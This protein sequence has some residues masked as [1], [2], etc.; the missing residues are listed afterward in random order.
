NDSDMIDDIVIDSKWCEDLWDRA[1]VYEGHLLKTGAPRCDVLY[2]DRTDYQKAFREK[3]HL[4]E[5]AKAVMYAPTFREGAKNGKRFVFSEIWSVDFKR[6]LTNLEKKFS[7]TWYLCVRV[8]PQLAP[9][10]DD[11][12]NPDVQDRIINVSKADDMYE[13][14]AGMDAYITDYSSACFEAGLTGM[15]VFLYA[16]DTKK[17]EKDRGQLLWDLNSANRHDIANNQKITPGMNLRLPFPLAATN[18][19]LEEDILEFDR[20]AYSKRLSDF[21]Q[22]IG[23]I[24]KGDAASVLTREILDRIH[25]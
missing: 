12:S 20:N 5:N 4:P 23:M 8:H 6:L 24:F 7:G 3:Y 15:P 2:G 16:D 18:E 19:E 25:E 9:T 14:L 22:G 17:Y 21:Y 1:L 10:F 13:I 11:Y